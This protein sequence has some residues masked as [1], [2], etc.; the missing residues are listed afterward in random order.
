MSS[1]KAA[2]LQSV[3]G[4]PSDIRLS[5]SPNPMSRAAA[6]AK[7]AIRNEERIRNGCPGQLA[8]IETGNSSGYRGFAI[9]Q[10]TDAG[11]Y[12]DDN[13]QGVRIRTP[14]ETGSSQIRWSSALNNVM[15]NASHFMQTGMKFDD[16]DELIIWTDENEDL[17]PQE[18]DEVPYWADTSYQ[19]SISRT[20][21]T[22]FMCAGNDENIDEEY[23]CVVSEN[24]PGTHLKRSISTSV[25]FE[26]ANGNSNWHSGFPATISVSSAKI[27]R[28]GVGQ[29]WSTEDRRTIHG[30]GQ[31]EYPVADAMN[32]TL[33]NNGS[34][35]WELSGVPIACP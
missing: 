2:I 18:F 17:E 3:P 4:A 20:N 21:G 16:G 8:D 10:N 11:S 12:T 28:N 23:E 13:A 32:S 22:W 7:D 5:F 30:C 26:N 15:T 35:S 19:F 1:L 9:F 29:A 34:A 25:F 24:A 31:G 6:A 33:K 14:S 27:F